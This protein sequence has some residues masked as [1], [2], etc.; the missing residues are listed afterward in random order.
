MNSILKIYKTVLTPARNALV[1]NIEYYL[2]HEANLYH[3]ELNFQYQRFDL[4]MTIVVKLPQEE[5]TAQDVGN[6]VSFTQDG[7]TWYYFVMSYAWRSTEALALNLSL[8]SVNTFRNDFVMSPKTSL[9]RHHED[10]FAATGTPYIYNRVIDRYTEGIETAKYQE[11]D[12]KLFQ[13]QDEL[14]W[15]LIYRTR[16]NLTPENISNPVACYCCANIPV[17][18]N[19][20]GDANPITYTVNTMPVG[21]YYYVSYEDDPTATFTIDQDGTPYAA[22]TSTI[23]MGGTFVVYSQTNNDYKAYTLRVI[24]FG[25]YNDELRVRMYGTLIG[26]ATSQQIS[27]CPIVRI[28]LSQDLPF[29]VDVNSIRIDVLNYARVN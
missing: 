17:I 22:R 14:D 27:T 7:K 12:E 2:A 19:R 25:R 28:S 10:R 13:T 26:N 8:D 24:V 1:D 23:T 15:F 9:F 29:S 11:S 20:Q 18:V 21:T 5:L 3:E 6:Y 16:D 4:D